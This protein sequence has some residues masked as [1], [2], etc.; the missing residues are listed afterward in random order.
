MNG[1][2]TVPL[3]P[4][5][6]ITID[7]NTVTITNP[8]NQPA[9]V[10]VGESTLSFVQTI[11]PQASVTLNLMVGGATLTNDSGFAVEVSYPQVPARRSSP[12][13]LGSRGASGRCVCSSP[14]VPPAPR[15]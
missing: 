12:T 1:N 9:K 2:S 15:S 7:G 10:T 13:I 11:P 8:S 4:G 6:S 14:T 5:Q 3:N